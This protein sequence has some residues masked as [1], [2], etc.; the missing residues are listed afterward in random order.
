MSKLSECVDLVSPACDQARS[1]YD[2]RIVLGVLAAQ[3]AATAAAAL[4]GGVERRYV[5]E[6]IAG[7]VD[8]AYAPLDEKPQVIYTDGDAVLGRKQ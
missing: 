6:I 5:A 8:G 3:L 1:T 7:T 4:A 2:I